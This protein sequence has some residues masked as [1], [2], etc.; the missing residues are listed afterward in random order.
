MTSRMLLV[1]IVV[2]GLVVCVMAGC[3]KDG[4]EEG[5]VGVADAGGPMGG[6]EG[7]GGP[8]MGG[9]DGPPAGPGP[10]GPGEPAAPDA[11]AAPAEAEDE[12][13]VDPAEVAE[14]V[15][16]ARAAKN[17]GDLD[18]ALKLVTDAIRAKPE[19]VEA[20]WVAAWILSEKPDTAL[21][22]GQFERVMKLGLGEARAK[23]ARAAVN[24]LKAREE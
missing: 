10:G 14:L 8:P 19:D 1:V 23:E 11:P 7:P 6:P 4:V 16:R 15:A 20:N 3:G 12:D 24:R 2:A 18:T 21:A 5:D 22:I 9:P 17:A 13:P